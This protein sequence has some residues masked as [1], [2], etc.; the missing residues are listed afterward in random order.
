M[1]GDNTVVRLSQLKQA[2]TQ[3]GLVSEDLAVNNNPIFEVAIL[4]N[5]RHSVSW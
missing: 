1:E 2:T 5:P 4:P 3:F